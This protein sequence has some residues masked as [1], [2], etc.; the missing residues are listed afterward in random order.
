MRSE[1]LSPARQTRI[2]LLL[3]ALILCAWLALHVYALWFHPLHWETGL[4]STLLV[5]VLTWLSVGLFII[6]HDAMHGSLAPLSPSWGRRIGTVALW[7]YANFSFAKQ[8]PQH[9]A[10]HH[11]PGSGT[12][13]DFHPNHPRSFWRWYVRF[14]VTYFRG[15]EILWMNVR[16]FLYILAGAPVAN[17]LLFFALPGLLSSLQ[18]FYFGTFLPHRHDGRAFADGHHARSNDYPPL[19]SLLSCFHFGYHY[20]HHLSPG[21]PWW[22]LPAIRRLRASAAPR[23]PAHQWALPRPGA[24]A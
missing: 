1:T 17:I 15:R 9:H 7:C 5:A 11:A 3:S 18:L 10:H 8:L 23:R 22:R 12:D 21:T 14:M 19:L 6:A 13:P 20:E 16:V 4:A 24:S 2:G